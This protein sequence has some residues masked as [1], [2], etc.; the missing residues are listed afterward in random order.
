MNS[1]LDYLRAY[2]APRAFWVAA[3]FT[4]A[5]L[6]R[7]PAV[8]LAFGVHVLDRTAERLLGWIARIPPQPVRT[9][10]RPRHPREETQR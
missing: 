1:T 6:V 3:L 4:V 5:V 8:A 9:V 7:V 10:T 2:T